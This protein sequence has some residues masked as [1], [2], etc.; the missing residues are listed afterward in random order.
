MRPMEFDYVIV[1]AGSAGCV[2]ASRLTEDS[3]VSVCLL[4]AGGPDRSV[5]IHAPAGVVA[6]VPRRIHN[7]AYE[8][9]PQAGLGGRCGY[10]PRGKTLG[11]SSSINAM[12]YVRGHR[13]DYDHWAA[14]G[15]LGWS[16]NEV[17]P[18]FRRAENNETFGDRPAHGRGGP[19]NVTALRS[20]SPINRAFLA[21]AAANGLPVIDDY[22]AGEPFGAFMY[23]VTQ[24]NG[25]RCSAAK[26]YL[27]PHLARP[28]LKVITG[29]TASRLAFDGA[30][31]CAVEA[32][33]GAERM[34]LRARREIVLSAG[35]FGSPQLLMLSGIGPGPEL[36]RLGIPVRRDLPGVGQN[37]QDHID[38][39]QTWRTRND[40][41]TF[42]LSLRGGAKLAAAALEWKTQRTGMIT[43]SIAES[44]AFLRS[45]PDVP[46][47]DLQLVFVQ[48]IVDDHARKLHWGHGISCHVDVLR[49]HSRGRVSLASP[50]PRAAPRIDP[51]FLDDERDMA[52]LLKGA[53]WQ[54]RIVESAPLNGIRG[55]MLYPVRADDTASI[56]ADIRARADTQYHPVGTCKMGRDP[57]AVVD[58]RLRVHGVPGLRVVDASI[59]PTIVGGNTN[60]PTI[61]IGEKAADLIRADAQAA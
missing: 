1:G 33:V 51:R 55:R 32:S 19:L 12:L 7:Y 25:E 8:T 56:A 27:T 22:N 44:G 28:N 52:L 23:Q 46:V 21:A 4:E 29:A 35:A 50:D 31:P 54:Q 45:S 57:L 60:A 24:R 59:M 20:P 15:N 13:W 47:P 14:L 36:Q 49:P 26:G 48:G 9:V 17:L 42:G 16:W 10:Q 18:Y 37:L 6:M 11:G 2:L 58:D 38:Y 34:S 53:R 3:Q 39:V 43:S 41:A 40:S 61:M 30:R 5:L